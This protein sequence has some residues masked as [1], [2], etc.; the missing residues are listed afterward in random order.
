M[1]RGRTVAARELTA[2]HVGRGDVEVVEGDVWR[3]VVAAGMGG[4]GGRWTVVPIVVLTLTAAVAGAGGGVVVDTGGGR[5]HVFGCWSDRDGDVRGVATGHESFVEGEEAGPVRGRS[6]VLGRVV[7]QIWVVIEEAEGVRLLFVVEIDEFG[8]VRV[9]RVL[10]GAVVG[11]RPGKLLGRR[12]VIYVWKGVEVG[13]AERGEVRGR[14]GL[15]E[16]IHG[17]RLYK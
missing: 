17:G 7:I 6:V 4:D 15:M 11:G 16:R 1:R 3:G 13:V 9:G 8:C 10:V 12:R 2:S 5:G 14:I